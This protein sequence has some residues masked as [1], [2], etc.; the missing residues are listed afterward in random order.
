MAYRLLE[1]TADLGIE[2]SAGTLEELFIESLRA[3]TDCITRLDRVGVDVT[4]ELA[5]VAGDLE[6]LMVNW[7]TEAIYLH[8]T[9]GLVLADG[10]VEIE[11]SGDGWSLTGRVSGEPFD[12]ARHGLKVLIKAV[13]FHQL[14]VQQRD[15]GWTARVIFDI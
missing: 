12:L 13:T 3:M 15:E 6:Q 5:L 14:E 8:E 4:R 11:R 9:E 2:V 7:L 1:H 10:D